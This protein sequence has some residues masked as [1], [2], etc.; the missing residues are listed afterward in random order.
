MRTLVTGGLGFI[1]SHLLKHIDGDI[2]IVDNCSNSSIE[3]AK[4]VKEY[5]CQVIVKNVSDYEP[6]GHYDYI[7]HLAS[8]VGPA[9][10]I[11]YAGQMSGIIIN[12]LIKVLKLAEKTGA[13]LML[14]S[15][16]EVYGKNPESK[17]QKEEQ[18]KIVP[19]KYTVRLEYGVAKLLMEITA[20]NY[21]KFHDIRYNI[22][23]PYNIIGAGQSFDA[24]FVIPRFMQQLK[25]KEVLTVFGNGKQVRCFTYV[26]DICDAMVKAMT[27]P[28]NQEIFNIGNPANKISINELAMKVITKFGSE[29]D[30]FG[31]ANPKIIYGEHY[32]EAWNKVPDISKAQKMLKWFPQWNLDKALEEIW[33]RG[34][35]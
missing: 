27:L 31:Y 29:T 6:N 22:I 18:E 10:V 24:G 5:E 23:R 15:S 20:M 21:A 2:E 19:G 7:Y 12:D 8:P 17:P 30:A 11:N 25:N 35:E 26:E 32:E 1:G 16:S 28:I 14:V 9:G 34:N 33:R 3:A 4:A 13:R